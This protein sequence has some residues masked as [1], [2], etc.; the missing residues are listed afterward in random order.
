[1]PED[2]SQ[3]YWRTIERAHDAVSI[4][5]GVKVFQQQCG[6]LQPDGASLHYMNSRQT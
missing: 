5:D 6:Q 2:H 1:M 4:Y 3:Q